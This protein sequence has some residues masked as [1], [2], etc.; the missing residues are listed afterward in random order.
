MVTLKQI[1]DLFDRKLKCIIKE[2]AV[3]IQVP[4]L[5]GQANQER[6]LSKEV[7]EVQSNYDENLPYVCSHYSKF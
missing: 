2:P 1:E 5:V 7:K 3:S 6:S 4:S